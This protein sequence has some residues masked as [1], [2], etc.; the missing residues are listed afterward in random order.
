MARKNLPHARRMARRKAL[1]ALY[2]WQMSGDNLADIREQFSHSQAD[3]HKA[4]P[5]Y[6]IEL[7]EEVPKALSLLDALITP[8]IDRTIEQ[9]D[10]VERAVLRLGAYE[11]RYR[12]EIPHRVVINEWVELSKLFGADQ[13]HKF[14]NGV[15][16]KVSKQARKSERNA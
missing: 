16:D 1:Q 14:I 5:D 3:M 6:F 4:D 2:Q 7:V 13:S 9:V 10:P 11:L 12:L 15:L 8:H